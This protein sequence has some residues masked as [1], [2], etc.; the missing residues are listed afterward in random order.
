MPFR[1]SAPDNSRKDEVNLAEPDGLVTIA[2]F[3]ERAKEEEG[4]PQ[5]AR[6]AEAIARSVLSMPERPATLAGLHSALLTYPYPL[7]KAGKTEA[8][9]RGLISAADNAH[10][11]RAVKFVPHAEPIFFIAIRY[12]QPGGGK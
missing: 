5:L 7:E 10:T 6:A 3:E 2:I 8:L 4:P 11:I 12:Y 9:G 1:V